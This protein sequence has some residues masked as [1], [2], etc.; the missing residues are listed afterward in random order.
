MSLILKIFVLLLVLGLLVAGGYYFYLQRN[1]PT[2]N[3]A[4]TA[5]R[6]TQLELL[7]SER[8]I[9]PILSFN[10]ERVWFMI[11][12]GRMYRQAV[13]GGEKEELVLPEAISSPMEIIWQMKGSDFIVVQN[14]DGH[15]RYQFYDGEAQVFLAYPEGLGK[16]VFLA[17]DQKIAYD[18]RGAAGYELK[19]ADPDGTNFVKVVDLPRGDYELAAS[20]VRPEVVLYATGSGAPLLLVNIDRGKISEVGSATSYEGVRFSPDGR[21]VLYSKSQGDRGDTGLFVYNL[22]TAREIDLQILGSLEQT[23]WTPNSAGIIL[24]SETGFGKYD[25]ES[26]IWKEIYQFEGKGQYNPTQILL[27]PAESTLFFVDDS[28]GYLYKVDY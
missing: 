19:V 6:A 9:S 16:A 7:V 18:W 4:Q 21:F 15:I 10:A 14:A 11:S 3:D 24:A 17:G 25:L 27:H 13:A 1:N 12:T 8:V 2:R 23:A 22:D 20:P 5:N 28:T 26:R